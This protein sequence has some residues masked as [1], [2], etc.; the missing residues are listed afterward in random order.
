MSTPASERAKLF[1]EE[2]AAIVVGAVQQYGAVASEAAGEI[3]NGNF[4]SKEWVRSMTRAFDVAALTSV[5]LAEA[6]MAGPGASL[7]PKSVSSE[8]MKFEKAAYAQVLYIVD[9]FKL[10]GG[11]E[12]VPAQRVNFVPGGLRDEQAKP[13]GVLTAGEESFWVVIQTAGLPGGTYFGTVGAR[14]KPPSPDQGTDPRVTVQ[15]VW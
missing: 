11:A 12:A 10:A 7:A 3:D 2:C 5:A 4:G 6:V 8:E 14:P 15:I 1:V 9:D 13:L